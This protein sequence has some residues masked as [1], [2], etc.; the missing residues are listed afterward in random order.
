MKRL[1]LLLIPLLILSSCSRFQ[2]MMKSTDMEAKYNAAV[3]YYDKK[4]YYH[5][6]QLFE[7]LISVFRGTSKAEMSYYYYTYCTYYVDDYTMAAYHFNNFVQSYPNS[8]HAEEMQYMY[9]YCYYLDSPIPSLDQS[10]TLEAI[11]KFQ[12]FINKFPESARVPDAN[13][14][15]DELRLKLE[16]KTFNNARQYYR[17][18]NHKAAVVAFSN[19]LKD[20]PYTIYKEEAL[21]LSFKSSYLY[22]LNSVEAKRVERLKLAREEYLKLVDNFPQSRYLR[23]AEKILES[24]DRQLGARNPGSAS[25]H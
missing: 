8:K 19:L 12:L 9:A 10:S 2:Q 5:A 17:T 24:I 6:L 3:K 4:D 23:D 1:L 13:K 25:V 21:F 14:M 18:E 16:E 20:Y 7:E 22:A 15:I 11:D